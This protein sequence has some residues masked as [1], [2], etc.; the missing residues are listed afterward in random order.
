MKMTKQRIIC[1]VDCDAF[2]VSCERAD[3]PSLRG[4]PVCVMT[5]AGQRGIIVSRS[6]EA[7][8]LGIKMGEPLFKVR[9][10]GIEGIFLSARH[11][12]YGEISAQVMAVLQS[13]SPDVEKVSVD[14]AYMDLT[15]LQRVYQKGYPEI[16]RDIRRAVWEQAGIPV[17]I[18]LSTTKTLAKLASD[19]AKKNGGIFVI[20]PDHI[21]DKI[22]SLPIEEVCGIGRRH[23]R[24]LR[25][26]GIFTINDFVRQDNAFVR[27]VFGIN[28]L[29]L[30]HELLGICTSPV[31]S[32]PQAP[33][34]IQDTSVLGCFTQDKSI[35]RAA[36]L[37]HI[38][39][40]CR[41][42]RRWNGFCGT[43]GVMLRT[44]EFRVVF[45]KQK[46]PFYTNSESEI[47]AAG[48][49]LLDR[50]YQ[51]G[52]TYRSTGIALEELSYDQQ[53]SLFAETPPCHDSPLSRAL[54]ALEAKFG[55]DIVKTGWV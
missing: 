16:I 26:L 52:V 13:F 42:L 20:P 5:G 8:Q 46:L 10:R 47:A 7:K 35:L 21:Q 3:N 25:F 36:L 53:P 28:G 24:H 14:E 9:E 15:S 49:A 51:P 50:L 6:Q 38:H 41:R 23:N 12:R 34:S 17:S 22:G 11:D 29:N 19:K 55:R 33:K 48:L 44:K 30:K 31:D 37:S 4:Q 2:F 43:A 45:I 40:A 18:G 1:L 54:D 27:K 32:R 39:Y